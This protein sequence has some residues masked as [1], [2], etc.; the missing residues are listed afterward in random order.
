MA[1]VQ[2][3]RVGSRTD[4]AAL[5][6][7]LRELGRRVLPPEP[8]QSQ[9]GALGY[10]APLVVPEPQ[11]L[12]PGLTEPERVERLA[13]AYRA[14]LYRRHG[15]RSR[16]LT[17]SRADGHP[18][19]PRLVQLARALL[20]GNVAPLAWVLFSFDRWLL[21]PLGEQGHPPKSGW[22][23]SP[24]RWK[25]QKQQEALAEARYDAPE[26]RSSPL[27]ATLYTDWRMMWVELIQKAPE[28]RE[29]LLEVV[30]RAF[31]GETWERRLAAAR[32]QTREMQQKID[33]EISQG[34]WPLE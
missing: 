23:W 31:P 11:R 3:G 28:T 15:L 29:Q 13:A 8:T 32:R 6:L 7:R 16:Y 22:V 25:D 5:E 20:E 2:L 17:R 26:Y 21:S 18:H 10:I 4:G 1:A 14:V 12:S 19:Y 24:K 9:P 34:G 27:A 30:E 33:E